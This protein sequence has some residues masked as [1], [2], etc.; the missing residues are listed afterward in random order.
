MRT[1]VRIILNHITMKFRIIVNGE[2]VARV[3]EVEKLPWG[4]TRGW[5]WNPN[6]A[7]MECVGEWGGDKLK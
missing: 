1:R 5:D 2:T 3:D 7:L 4:A 6:R